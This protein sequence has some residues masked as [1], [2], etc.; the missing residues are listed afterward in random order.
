MALDVGA[1]RA[2]DWAGCHAVGWDRNAPE[3]GDLAVRHR[4]QK[5]SYPLGILVNAEGRRFVDEGA[6]YRNYTYAK[7]G[8]AVLERVGPA[9]A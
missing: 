5:H 8:R 3:F 7:Y 6:D 1:A 9:G 2:G 4:F